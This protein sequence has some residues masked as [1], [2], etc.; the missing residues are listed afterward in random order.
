VKPVTQ[1]DQAIELA[2]VLDLNESFQQASEI[3]SQIIQALMATK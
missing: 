3:K 1:L 2:K